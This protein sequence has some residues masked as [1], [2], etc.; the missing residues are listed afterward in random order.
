MEKNKQQILKTG[1]KQTADFKI[2]DKNRKE[3]KQKKN[4][5]NMKN[6]NRKK[7]KK[8]RK[9]FISNF[10]DPGWYSNLQG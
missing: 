10:T 2:D 1:K 4:R 5:Q 9:I 6:K 8:N 3:K 7:Q